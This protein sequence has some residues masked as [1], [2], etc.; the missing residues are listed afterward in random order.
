MILVSFFSEDI[1]SDEIKKNDIFLNIKVT[2]I[3][4][5]AFF[6]TPGKVPHASICVLFA[7][8]GYH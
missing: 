5:F 3:E 6:G 4:R 8:W 1:F 7:T 2:K